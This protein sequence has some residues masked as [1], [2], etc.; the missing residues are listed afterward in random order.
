MFNLALDGRIEFDGPVYRATRDWLND[1]IRRAGGNVF[2]VL[3]AFPIAHRGRV[4]RMPALDDVLAQF[5]D[6]ELRAELKAIRARDP[7][8]SLSIC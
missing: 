7:V 1:R 4:P 6:R 8:F 5:E 3:I 2:G